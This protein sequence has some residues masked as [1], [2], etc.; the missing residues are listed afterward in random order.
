MAT[1][2]E[3]LSRLL[4]GTDKS[5]LTKG[6]QR[7]ESKMG[8]SKNVDAGMGRGTV[9][10][11]T[12]KVQMDTGKSFKQAFKEAR[13][14]GKGTFTWNGKK[15]STETADDKSKRDAFMS[16]SRRLA[17]ADEIANRKTM[18]SDSG[19]TNPSEFKRGGMIKMG[20]AKHHASSRGDGCAQRGKTKGR[21]V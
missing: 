7:E 21:M 4:F 2:K 14:A 10:M 1:P 12:N 13:D 11:D 16:E 8:S 9:Q 17:D 18:E 5:I 20:S 19:T 6:D 3:K 15:Y